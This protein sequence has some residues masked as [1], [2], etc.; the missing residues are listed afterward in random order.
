MTFI[1]MNQ[2]QHRNFN[3]EYQIN[4]KTTN[5][6][7]QI[8]RLFFFFFWF[9]ALYGRLKCL[10]SPLLFLLGFLFYWNKLL[11]N[12]L[13]TKV[14]V[15]Y[16]GCPSAHTSVSNDE[17]TMNSTRQLLDIGKSSNKSMVKTSQTFSHVLLRPVSPTTIKMNCN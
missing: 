17:A 3:N 6:R 13:N 1:S 2:W 7:V 10:T 11:N 5:R 16:Q 12:T 4:W 15:K 9:S 8:N 14:V